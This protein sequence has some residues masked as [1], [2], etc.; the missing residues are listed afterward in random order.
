MS[1][2]ATPAMPA[3]TTTHKVVDNEGAGR[4]M[5]E[6]VINGHPIGAVTAMSG[7]TADIKAFVD[8]TQTW[9]QVMTKWGMSP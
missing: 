9:D 4:L 5:I 7:P 1:D 2:N 6:V 8:G 3:I